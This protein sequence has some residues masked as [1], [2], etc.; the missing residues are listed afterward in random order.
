MEGRERGGPRAGVPLPLLCEA[1]LRWDPGLPLLL[2]TSGPWT[3][4][5]GG[6]GGVRGEGGDPRAHL[7]LR[8]QHPWKWQ[9]E[10]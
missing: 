1:L 4:R 7:S 9:P 10:H 2:C 6:V 5:L 8:T 3:Q